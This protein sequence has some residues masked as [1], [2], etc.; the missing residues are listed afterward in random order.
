MS[1][2]D[3]KKKGSSGISTVKAK[4][5]VATPAGVLHW[6]KLREPDEKFDN[7]YADIKL[8][9]EAIDMLHD[10]IHKATVEALHEKLEKEAG[11]SLKKCDF[12]GWFESKLKD[13]SEKDK[14]KN[15]SFKCG[16]KAPKLN[17]K[18]EPITHKP[19][20]LYDAKG[21][22]LDPEAIDMSRARGS[23]VQ[24]LFYPGMYTGPLLKGAADPTVTLAGVRILKLEL[25]EG[26]EPANVGE[27]SEEDLA[28]LDDSFQIDEDLSQYAKGASVKG[29]GIVAQASKAAPD[30]EEEEDEDEEHPF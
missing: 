10:R 5:V 13:A 7:F 16:K 27:V 11:K 19:I 9:P 26:G 2:K 4:Q 21:N 25:Y 22:L 24:L 29:T 15:K 8:S 6:N 17:A 14:D 30:E 23:L 3:G 18:G 1:E 12:E 20:P 28:A